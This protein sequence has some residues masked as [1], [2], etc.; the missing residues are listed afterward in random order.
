[1][2]H[3]LT[4]G[5]TNPQLVY[6][7]AT[8]QAFVVGGKD[9]MGKD[10]HDVWRL[11]LDAQGDGFEPLS[12]T[13]ATLG[14]VLAST[15]TYADGR[16]WVLDQTRGLFGIKIARLLRIDPE[17]GAT[18]VVGAWPM[19]GLSDQRWLSVDRDGALL[20]TFSSSRLGGSHT[21]LRVT[22][23]EVPRLAG[24]ARG[25]RALLVAP[26]ADRAGYTLLGP[27]TKGSKT[28]FE[29]RRFDSLPFLPTPGPSWSPLQGCL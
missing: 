22:T 19:L 7:S 17:S 10:L 11:S 2:G 18:T 6:S 23:D 28:P 8:G 9:T 5:S 3:Q 21:M 25:P 24:I 13:G 1:V 27:A 14:T 26:I 12:L 20:L 15:F 4:P 16:L 29:V